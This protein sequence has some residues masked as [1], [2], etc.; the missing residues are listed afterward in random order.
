[1]IM[2]DYNE[3]DNVV[4]N[5][6]II[7]PTAKKDV[8]TTVLLIIGYVI[9][10]AVILFLSYLFIDIL[11]SYNPDDNWAPLGIV[12]L[13]YMSVYGA[14]I[15]IVPTIL[16]AVSLA[17][18]KKRELSNTKRVL[19]QILTIVPLAIPVL[20]FVLSVFIL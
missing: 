2:Q 15:D 18:V 6:T 14:L 12:V 19:S 9:A 1:M 7:A 3:I 17:L 10:G 13:M 11:I 5:D 16:G 20:Y 4:D 8:A